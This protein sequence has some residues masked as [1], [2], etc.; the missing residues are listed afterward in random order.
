M[1]RCKRSPLQSS[2][3]TAPLSKQQAI[4]A[5]FAA[6]FSLFSLYLLLKYTDIDVNL[7]FGFVTTVVAGLCFKEA[8]D[9]I[10]NSIFM[11]L[12]A[13]N[14]SVLDL[15]K[16]QYDGEPVATL[17]ASDVLSA[18]LALAVV[19]CYVLNLFPAFTFVFGNALAVGIGA[20]VLALIKPDSFLVAAGLLT[21]LCFYDMFWVLYV[22]LA[23]GP[24]TLSLLLSPALMLQQLLPPISSANL[25]LTGYAHFLLVCRSL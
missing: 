9:P 21:G 3:L 8:L 4:A 23:G 10:F 16:P 22:L 20:R 6:S 1:H 13:N 15:E 11:A 2:E 25:S 14:P 18:A 5:P 24:L 19:T 12:G 17:M 7:I